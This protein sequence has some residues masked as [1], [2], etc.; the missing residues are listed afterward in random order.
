[1]TNDSFNDT[2]GPQK[3]PPE[4]QDVLGALDALG[5]RDRAA[6]RAGLE[7]RIFVRTRPMLSCRAGDAGPAHDSRTRPR[8]RIEPMLQRRWRLAAGIAIA[9]ATVLIAGLIVN[10][11]GAPQSGTFANDIDSQVDEFLEIAGE[12]ERRLA[13]GESTFDVQSVGLTGGF[14]GDG[15]DTAPLL[16]DTL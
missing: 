4:L 5:Q 6:A 14:W 9:A 1:M 15:S 13:A 8:L 7:D 2:G 16:E 3:L 11:S 12:L 10:R